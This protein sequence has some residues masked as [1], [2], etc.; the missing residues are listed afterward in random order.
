MDRRQKYETQSRSHGG[1]M[2]NLTSVVLGRPPHLIYGVKR[3]KV[4]SSL[5]PH[6]I[7]KRQALGSKYMHSFAVEDS[8]FS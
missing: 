6:V 7:L 5:R 4:P 1:N 2:V 8:L 3:G